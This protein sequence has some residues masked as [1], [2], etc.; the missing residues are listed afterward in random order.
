M[1]GTYST[2]GRDEKFGLPEGKGPLGRPIRR[3]EDN[4]EIY[5]R[6]ISWEGVDWMR[7]RRGT[8]GGLL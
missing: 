7:L 2:H 1:G 8:S 5:I 4:I 6:E 3:W